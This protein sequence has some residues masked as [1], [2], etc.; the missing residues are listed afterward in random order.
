M[1]CGPS[2]ECWPCRPSLRARTLLAAPT[3]VDPIRCA[4]GPLP[5]P[6]RG[7]PAPL[8]APP[9][10]RGRP[11]PPPTP[12]AGSPPAHPPP[13]PPPGG[14]SPPP[15]GQIPAGQTA[16]AGPD[17]RKEPALSPDDTTDNSD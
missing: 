3:G 6:D 12:P 2:S 9:P 11:P 14:G 7:P 4:G 15:A 8:A 17:T 1:T 10:A 5:H 16:S 13:R